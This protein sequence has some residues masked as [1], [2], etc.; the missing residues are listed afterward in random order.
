M[1]S[2]ETVTIIY[3]LIDNMTWIALELVELCFITM[4]CVYLLRIPI[5]CLLYE[6]SS[7]RR[8]VNVTLSFNPKRIIFMRIVSQ[9][10]GLLKV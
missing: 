2:I 4:L 6:F 3:Y 7:V 8:E 10:H 1:D 9:G 5:T